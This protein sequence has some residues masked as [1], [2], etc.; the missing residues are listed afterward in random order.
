MVF[1]TFIFMLSAEIAQL[2]QRLATACT[3]PASNPGESEI[4]RIRVDQPWD[5]PILLYN[6]Y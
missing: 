5:L 4:F 6:A 1:G 2:V 3:V